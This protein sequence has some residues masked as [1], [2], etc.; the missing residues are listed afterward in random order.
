[1]PARAS[2]FTG[3]TP[4]DHGVRTN[5]I[6][7]DPSLPTLPGALRDAGYRTHAVGK[8]HLHTYDLP[9]GTDVAAEIDS[10]GDADVVAPEEFPEAQSLWNGGRHRALPEPYYGLET[11]DFTGGH[12]SWIFGEYRQWL[13][14]EHPDVAA[15]LRE[16][17]PDNDP[18]PAPQTFD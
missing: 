9:N 2:L 8:L 10:A 15:R 5:G 7:L 11:A 18:R 4:R 3:L 14:G 13:E 6:P 12:V 1:M 16:D 17:H